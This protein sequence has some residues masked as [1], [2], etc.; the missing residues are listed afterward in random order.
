MHLKSSS[1]HEDDFQSVDSSLSSVEM[2]I[3]MT[4]IAG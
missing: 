4:I 1:R 2:V 3:M